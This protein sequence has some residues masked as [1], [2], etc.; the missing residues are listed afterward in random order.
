MAIPGEK[1]GFERRKMGLRVLRQMDSLVS[2][3]ENADRNFS[4][5]VSEIPAI[6]NVALD[7]LRL[8][9]TVLQFKEIEQELQKKSHSRTGRNRVTGVIAIQDAFQDALRG[10]RDEG[11]EAKEPNLGLEEP[12]EEPVEEPAE[13]PM[14]LEREVE[15]PKGMF[16]IP[17]LLQLIAA[18]EKTGV[19]QVVAEN[20][21]IQIHF[22]DGQLMSAQSVDGPEDNRL[23]SILVR[24]GVLTRGQ[25]QRILSD[26]SGKNRKLGRILREDGIADDQAIVAALQHQLKQLFQ[27]A[28]VAHNADV[29][30]R[31]GEYTAPEGPGLDVVSFLL[32]SIAAS[33]GPT[34]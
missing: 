30:F 34:S 27:R 19:V 7:L 8:R 4:N 26:S 5:F 14:P 1:Q 29:N 2:M 3:L 23:G 18:H 11:D 10:Y 20:E 16:R 22:A 21:T 6:K 31:E 28:L 33:E 13:K 15:F 17:D 24:H 25:L 12:L 9:E 32:S